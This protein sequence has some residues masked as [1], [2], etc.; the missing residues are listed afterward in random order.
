MSRKSNDNFDS[1]VFAILADGLD[2]C[3]DQKRG[4][5]KQHEDAKNLANAAPYLLTALEEVLPNTPG[6]NTKDFAG[7]PWLVKARFA[8]RMAR[9]GK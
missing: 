8:I 6:W 9:G 3:V 1:S 7:R 5:T 4:W 2:A